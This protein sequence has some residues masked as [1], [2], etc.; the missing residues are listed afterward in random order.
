MITAPFANYPR[1]RL[2]RLVQE[3]FE[4][5]ECASRSAI[6]ALGTAEFQN[7]VAAWVYLQS[8]KPKEDDR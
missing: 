8:K 7:L 4:S 2:E 1:A 3:G 5:V 6:P